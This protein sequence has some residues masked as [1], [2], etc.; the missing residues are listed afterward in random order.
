VWGNYLNK[1]VPSSRDDDRIGR[2]RRETYTTDPF[3]M[4]LFSDCEFTITES[5]PEL[6]GFVSTTTDYLSVVGTEGDRED[7]IGMADETTSSLASVEIPKTKSFI[8]GGRKSVLT[9]RRD[10]DV[11]DKVV[12]T[13]LINQRPRDT[14][15]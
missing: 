9:V 2:I 7:I 10:D 11:L 14:V 3:A 5:I 1:S 4:S 15:L 12:V 8:P 13:L 6:D